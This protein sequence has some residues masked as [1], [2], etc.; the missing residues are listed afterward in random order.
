MRQPSFAPWPVLEEL[1]ACGKDRWP[2]DHWE[3]CLLRVLQNRGL[4]TKYANTESKSLIHQ[5]KGTMKT[6]VAEELN[7]CLEP[8]YHLVPWKPA[9]F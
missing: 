2:A 9:P 6:P 1:E 4:E 7:V 8:H 5:V 3:C